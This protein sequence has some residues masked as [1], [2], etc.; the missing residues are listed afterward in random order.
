MD[1]SSSS[2]ERHGAFAAVFSGEDDPD[3]I[4]V[5]LGNLVD[6][7][8]ERYAGSEATAVI[9]PHPVLPSAPESPSRRSGQTEAA[10]GDDVALDF[11]RA[12]VDRRSQ[13]KP[14]EVLRDPAATAVGSPSDRMP[15]APS[16]SMKSAD[17]LV[18]A[19]VANSLAID[20]STPGRV[21]ER[22][23]PGAPA[24]QQGADL[25]LGGGPTEA[26]LDVGVLRSRTPC[27]VD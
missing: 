11:A 9:G 10:L 18:S 22:L 4:R 6:L 26:G 25:D 24:S 17:C 23:H 19:S 12:P 20:P 21:P 13:R 16:M 3:T 2:T 14:V 7:R 15:S 5:R 8:P 27:T 1:R